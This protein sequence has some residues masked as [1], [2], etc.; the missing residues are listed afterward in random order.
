MT[1]LSQLQSIEKHIR[2]NALDSKVHF[3][4]T[5]EDYEKAQRD[6]KID[7][8]D[9]CIIDDILNDETSVVTCK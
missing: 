2:I 8:N 1:T 7:T 9:V 5:P 6:G 4:D 3:F